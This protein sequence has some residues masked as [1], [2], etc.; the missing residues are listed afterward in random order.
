[1]SLKVLLPTDFSEASAVGVRAGLGLA[2]PLGAELVL[3]HVFDADAIS[4]L[5]VVLGGTTGADMELV[6]EARRAAEKRLEEVKQEWLGDTPAETVV[7]E[8]RSPARALTRYASEQGIGLIVVA[9]HGRTGL[10]HFVLGSVTEKIVR[11][12]TCRVL[13][14]PV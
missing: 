9:T 4:A 5:P 14:V 11:L 6:S 2:D 1:M 3:A 13:T 12:A 10:E 8:G 7:L